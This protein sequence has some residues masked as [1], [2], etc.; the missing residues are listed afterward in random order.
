M[1]LRSL[2][3]RALKASVI[4]PVALAGCGPDTRDFTP[5]ACDEFQFSVRGLEPSVIPDVIALRS[6]STIG[7]EPSEPPRTVSSTGTACATATTP[8]SCQASFD[9]LS[10][11]SGFASACLQICTDYFLATTKGDA[12]NAVASLEALKTF[13]GP[14]DTPQEAMLVAFAQGYNLA[15]GQPDRGAAKPEGTGWEVLAT[16]G[17]ACGPGTKLMRHYL[18][19]SREGALS[20]K[21]SEVIEYGQPNCAI[22]RRP[23]GLE[24]T[25]RSAC[26]LALGRYFAEVAH[27]EG[28]SVPAFEQLR[29]ELE[30]LGAPEALRQRAMAAALEELGHTRAMSGLARR[31]GAEPVMPEV[32]AQPLRSRFALALDNAAEGCVRETFGALVASYQAQH[33]QDAEVRAAM[34]DIA[35]DETRHAE[36]SW[37]MAEWLE[38]GLSEGERAAVSQAR[39]E[40]AAT[41]ARELEAPVEE[42]L[43]SQVG[44][45]PPEVAARLLASMLLELV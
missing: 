45:P 30:L 25:G 38:A 12:V 17:L 22:G 35:E 33:A 37:A 23:P 24:S 42:A 2:I 14:I 13:L 10:P 43:V 4:A 1:E 29:A 41:L 40:A 3:R 9:A 8:A 34:V 44:V 11:M 32:K 5:L 21:R 31:F 27:L 16:T 36:L 15:C 7:T 28:A 20:E 39:R 26:D 18:S 6:R 19:V